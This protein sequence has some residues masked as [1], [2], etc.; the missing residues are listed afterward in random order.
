MYHLIK[1]RIQ[2]HTASSKCFRG[3]WQIQRTNG[4]QHVHRTIL[5]ENCLATLSKSTDVDLKVQAFNLYQLVKSCT[6]KLGGFSNN[7]CCCSQSRVAWRYIHIKFHK[8]E[9]D[10]QYLFEKKYTTGWGTTTF[11]MIIIFGK[12]RLI[13]FILQFER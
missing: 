3:H 7:P 6:L 13:S 4:I 9:K 8:A 5:P 2:F 1:R 11:E 12:D 10:C